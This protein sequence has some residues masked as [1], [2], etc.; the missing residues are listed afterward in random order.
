MEAVRC[1]TVIE[2]GMAKRKCCHKSCSEREALLAFLDSCEKQRTHCL[3]Q[4][5]DERNK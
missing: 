1:C 4:R 5:L 2:V 3:G